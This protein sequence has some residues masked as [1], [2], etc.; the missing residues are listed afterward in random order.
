MDQPNRLAGVR[1]IESVWLTEPG[2][3]WLPAGRSGWKVKRVVQVPMKGAIR[4]DA[5]TI[6]MHPATVQQLKAD[7]QKNIR[8]PY[9]GGTT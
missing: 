1:I 4:L 9:Y 5:N 7:L 2:V 3:A 6:V 8:W